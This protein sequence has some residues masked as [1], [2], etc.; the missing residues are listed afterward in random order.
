MQKKRILLVD[1]E[2]DFIDTLQDRLEMAGYKADAYYDGEQDN[3]AVQSN[4]YDVAVIDL[5]LKDSDGITVMQRL[6]IFRPLL[7]CIV[8]SGQGTLRMAVEAMKQGAYEF[9]EKPCDFEMVT[10]TIDEAFARK[11][12]HEHRIFKAAKRVYSKLEQAMVDATF[13]QAGQTKSAQDDKQK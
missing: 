6:K 5:I 12:D 1:D 11:Q 4:E 2:K 13:A 8:L 9:L 10:Q 3:T 7:E